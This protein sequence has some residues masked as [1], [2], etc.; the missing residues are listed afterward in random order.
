MVLNLYTLICRPFHPTLESRQIIGPFEVSF[1]SALKIIKT[2]D[3][4]TIIMRAIFISTVFLIARA[5]ELFGM[6]TKLRNLPSAISVFIALSLL[7][8]FFA[9]YMTKRFG[10][11]METVGA[12]FAVW[13]SSSFIGSFPGGVLADRLGRKG[14]IILGLVATA[15][16]H[17]ALGLVST[18]T[19]F[20]I[21]GF[22]QR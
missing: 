19:L 6:F 16:S 13:T 5:K 18:L 3:N 8:P 9:F 20:F 1:T 21:F 11:G 7:L 22:N 14:M 12:L 2:G 4:T 15:L 17:L 10:V